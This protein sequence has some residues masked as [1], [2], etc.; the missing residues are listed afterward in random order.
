[1]SSNNTTDLPSERRD[2]KAVDT[3][4]AKERPLGDI[5]SVI[6]RY[7]EEGIP[8]VIRGLNADPK[9]SPPP[10][11]DPPKKHGEG[12]VQLSGRFIDLPFDMDLIWNTLLAS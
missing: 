2:F 8:L 9:W 5:L 7:E 6:L 11:P 1:M 10:G 12:E 4:S 3:I